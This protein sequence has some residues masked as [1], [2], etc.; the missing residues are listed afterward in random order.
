M[1]FLTRTLAAALLAAAPMTLA[2]TAPASAQALIDATRPNEVLAIAQ[3]YGSGQLDV[4][5]VGDPMI[6]GEME[7]VTYTVV[8]YGCQ[9]NV[10]CTSLLFRAGFSKPGFSTGDMNVWNAERLFG[11]AYIDNEG[12][13]IIEMTVNLF[14][15]VSAQNLDDTF[16]WWRVVLTQFKEHINW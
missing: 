9:N 11:R 6:I 15:G 1:T 4:D 10:N 8:F 13:P 7:D 5:G 12:D 16:D 2:A 3:N 14:G